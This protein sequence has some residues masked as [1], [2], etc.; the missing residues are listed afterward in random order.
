MRISKTAFFP[1]LL[2]AVTLPLHAQV[3]PSAYAKGISVT[4]GGEVSAFQPD[5]AGFGIPQTSTNRLYGIGAFVDAKFTP[6][7]QIEAEGRWLRFNQLD[8]IYE[9]SWLIGPRLPIY[10]L[11]FWRATPYGKVLIGYGHLNFEDNNGYGRYTDIAY[12]GGLDIKATNRINI[13]AP[14]FEYQ[15]WP[16]W[17]EG[18]AK[19][20]NLFPYGLSVGVSYRVFGPR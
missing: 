18:G 15:Q 5:Y 4:G 3:A 1:L 12:G 16:G 11:R 13:R 10:K 14:D 6:W 2:V 19:T 20:Y 9:D 8:G 17:S 7:I